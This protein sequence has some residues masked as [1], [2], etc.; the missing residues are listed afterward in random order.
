MLNCLG[1]MAP[2]PGPGS[3]AHSAFDSSSRYET[4]TERL[5]AQHWP[6]TVQFAYFLTGDPSAAEE[7]AQDALVRALG[8][9][10]NLRRE[11]AFRSY[12]YR[13]VANLVKSD[14]RRRSH[15]RRF[16]KQADPGRTVHPPDI[17]TQDQIWAVLQGLPKRQ[18][19]ALVLRYCEDMSEAQ[20]ADVM[21]TSPKAIKSL[22][23]RGL[24]ALR[25]RREELR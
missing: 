10:K 21:E 25:E 8:R 13:T 5:Y 7:V 20:A 1:D 18:R 23:T 15:E 19:I 11:E 12:V 6:S 22:I 4:R 24:S 17:E 3:G 16:I 14:H 9:F 2:L